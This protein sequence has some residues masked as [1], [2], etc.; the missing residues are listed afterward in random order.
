MQKT[1]IKYALIIGALFSIWTLLEYFTGLSDSAFGQYSRYVVMVI[2]AI[3]LFFGLKEVKEKN[4]N[5]EINYGQLLFA[6]IQI[7]LY[8]GIIFAIFCFFYFSY[9]NTDFAE[10]FV[11]NTTK[12]M[13]K[14]NK[15]PEEI[16]K[17][18]ADIRATSKINSQLTSAF[19]GTAIMGIL[20]TTILSMV[21]RNKDTFTQIVQDKK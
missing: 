3:G 17:V 14:E 1:A 20:F 12:A 9:I 18:V 16:K 7:S 8:T 15:T 10:R 13:I 21:L 6:G 5:N 2:I 19:V 4:Y 11:E